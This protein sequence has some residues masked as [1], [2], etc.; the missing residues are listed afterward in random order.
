M[1]C[2]K[3]GS[4]AVGDFGW[5]WK[6]AAA[7]FLVRAVAFLLLAALVPAVGPVW[8]YKTFSVIV[9]DLLFAGILAYL[10]MT[11]APRWRC[12]TCKHMWR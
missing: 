9:P 1:T 4:N 2:P 11:V 10:S 12:R 3:C 8:S 6:L 7:L 5:V